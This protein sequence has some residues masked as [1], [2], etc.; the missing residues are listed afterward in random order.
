MLSAGG[1]RPTSSRSGWRSSKPRWREARRVLTMAIRD[2]LRRLEKAMEGNLPSIELGD[3]TTYHYNR[4]ELWLELLKYR[5][6][7]VRADY[8]GEVRPEPPEIFLMLA[9]AQDQ[10]A[11]VTR[12]WP[13]WEVRP[14]LCAFDLRALVERGELVPVAFA[15]GY[16]PVVKEGEA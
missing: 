16:P 14:R 1:T 15:P 5:F 10:R 8:H 13:D 11:A 7:S 9:R 4:G 12:L 2:R 3:G 6:S